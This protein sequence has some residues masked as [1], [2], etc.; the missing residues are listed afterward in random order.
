VGAEGREVEKLRFIQLLWAKTQKVFEEA[1]PAMPC[2]SLF[3][4]RAEARA[5][6]VLRGMLMK[7]FDGYL[8]SEFEDRE[9]T[10]DAA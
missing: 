7:E 8:K 2:P 5:R 3:R 10:D 6:A 9:V 1:L 4:P